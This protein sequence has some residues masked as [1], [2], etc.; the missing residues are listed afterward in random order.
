MNCRIIL[1]ITGLLF[2]VTFLTAC[3]AGAE[4]PRYMQVKSI[5]MELEG[6]DATFNIE[7][8]LDIIA[9][10]Y[11]LLMGTKGIEPAMYNLFNDFDSI[12]V[13]NVREDSAMVK[14]R[15]VS[16]RDPEQGGNVYFHDSHNLGIPVDTFILVFPS[17]AER[18]FYNVS[19]TPNTFFEF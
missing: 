8:E 2:S 14:V 16:Y 19:S 7:Y 18:I 5:T 4:P 13:L 15:N 12:Q 11:V 1:I 9:K 3:A 10:M 6:P 17:G